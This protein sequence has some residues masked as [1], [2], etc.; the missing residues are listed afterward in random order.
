[1]F[2][3][4]LGFITDT[5]DRTIGE[6]RHQ[7]T[8]ELGIK[9]WEGEMPA[10]APVIEYAESI[11]DLLHPDLREAIE[12]GISTSYLQGKSY[13]SKC[14][15]GTIFELFEEIEILLLLS[16]PIKSKA[17]RQ[18]FAPVLCSLF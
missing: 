9:P 16:V 3:I 10:I 17:V 12:N 1:M 2:Y 14:F 11:S 8:V 15:E 13:F 6:K 5:L 4:L 7:V 18:K